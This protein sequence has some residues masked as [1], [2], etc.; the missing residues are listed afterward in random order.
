MTFLGISSCL[1]FL[2]ISVASGEILN[3]DGQSFVIRKLQTS[4][5]HDTISLKFRTN[6]ANGNLIYSQGT[7]G[8]VFS[9]RMQDN[10][11]VL[12]LNLGN[13]EQVNT[14]TAGSLLDDSD[15]HRI[16]ISRNNRDLNLTVDDHTVEHKITGDFVRLD[17][18]DKLYLGG[19][20][21][22]SNYDNVVK[23]NFTGCIQELLL[24][25][26]NIIQELTSE[27]FL[28][29]NS[30]PGNTCWL[31]K[32]PSITF[33]SA[34]A[35]IKVDAPIS[36]RLDI[37]FDFRTFNEDGVLLYHK[38]SSE[39]FLATSLN[40]RKLLINLETRE[41]NR[42][43]LILEPFHTKN[44]NDGF[45]HNLQISLKTNQLLVIVD[46]QESITKRQMS[47]TSGQYYAIGAGWFAK[48]GFIGCIR[49]LN[50]SDVLISLDELTSDRIVST[51]PGDIIQNGCK[52][53]DRCHQNPCEHRGICRQDHDSFTCDC[54]NTGYTGA[55]CHVPNHPLSCDAYR[56]A[57]SVRQ[58]QSIMIDVD[59]SG[60]LEPFQVTCQFHGDR[61]QTFLH[62]K[63]EAPTDVTGYEEPGSYHQDLT[64]N[65]DL[66][67]ITVLVNKSYSCKQFIKYECK[68]ARLFNTPYQ[69]Q[70]HFKPFTWWMSR[71]N[72]KMSYWG[73]SLPESRKCKCGLFG[74]C[75]DPTK[76]CN[77][78]S[79]G[80]YEWG[81]D[82]G[83]LTEKEFLPIRSI[84]IGDTS[85][86]TPEKRARYTI[87]PL[88]CEGDMMFD[89]VVTFRQ[90]DSIIPVNIETTGFSWDIYLQFKTT[91][92]YGVL[93]HARGPYDFIKLTIISAKA[94]QF[95]FDCGSGSQKIEIETP[96]KLSDDNWHSILVEWNQ[97]EATLLVDGKMSHKVSN[98]LP[99]FRSMELKSPLIV[100]ASVDQKEGY[101]G[102]LR[103]LSFNGQF[104]DLVRIAKEGDS[105]RSLYGIAPGCVGKCQSS[106]CLNNGTCY[107]RYSSY[108]CDC[109]WT[110]FKGRICADEFGVNLKSDNFIKYDF[111]STLST[112]EEFIRVGFTTTENK[113]LILGISSYSGEYLNLMM[114]TSGHLRLVFD[115]GFE[116][117]E[118]IIKSENFA[119][120]QHHDVIIKRSDLGR[121]MTIMVDGYEP[122]VYTFNIADKADAQF[123][124]LKSIYVGRNETMSTGEG[125]VGCISRV[126][127]DDHFPL[128]R[129][130][131][132]DRRSN[133]YAFPDL[134][135]VREDSCGIE[136]VTHPPEEIETRP[137]PLGSHST[138]EGDSRPIIA[139]IGIIV[140]LIVVIVVV[141]LLFSGRFMAHYKGD[142]VTH[143]D[144]GAR[145]ALDPDMA[146]VKSK[147]GPDITKKKEYFI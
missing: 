123:N 105:G 7:Q 100:G 16:L 87:G 4:S 111:E 147:T 138:S 114:S 69:L 84:R 13:Q 76:W 53:V 26:T 97:K 32:L 116:R 136:S 101:L 86:G 52:M 31:K 141:A 60:P 65:A 67:Q 3:L 51:Y 133:V 119:L 134:D 139:A 130:F 74:N 109:Q 54:T 102:C 1:I 110:A 112:L 122:I 47:M 33:Q 124:R 43:S 103:A 81:I 104:I 12:S 55:V 77:C 29:S 56:I 82:E 129:L 93:F 95:V 146:V 89:N 30:R 125:F 49:N 127:F 140:T 45:W 9:L 6:S 132:Q 38:F 40:K 48:T 117:Q 50:V 143:E 131:Q 59:G 66:D 120:G 145:D 108:S 144:K 88:I 68:N 92:E 137:P 79:M 118:L 35:Y 46:E 2:F 11:I 78:D 23:E 39:G 5:F 37:S 98:S 115:F 142:Y 21:A 36:N 44:L 121:R 90:H 14:I 57:N 63:N 18:N 27:D 106:P 28:D 75:R 71:N 83:E 96:Y 15:W 61:T 99:K 19:L 22:I 113:G 73:G 128:K 94:I 58:K 107:E 91:I 64:Y 126:S 85:T 24:N 25:E 62:H 72:Q 42:S 135:S 10:K 80:S 17:L 8:D 70:K 20:P 34:S 41:T